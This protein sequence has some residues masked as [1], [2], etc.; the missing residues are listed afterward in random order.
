MCG[1]VLRVCDDVVL[2]L[3]L[4]SFV[5][6]AS[7]SGGL[8]FLRLYDGTCNNMYVWEQDII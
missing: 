6:F 4:V 8:F 1:C 2:Q 5:C 7:T 3:P